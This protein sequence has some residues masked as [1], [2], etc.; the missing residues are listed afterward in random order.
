ME[1]S[2]VKGASTV[3]IRDTGKT[4]AKLKV[5]V[6]KKSDLPPLSMES[7]AFAGKK[8]QKKKKQVQRMIQEAENL[9]AKELGR[10]SRNRKRHAF[11]E[12]MR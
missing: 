9:M 1:K 4:G 6:I 8:L 12:T 3:I 2:C 5:T 10:P 7:Y 11:W